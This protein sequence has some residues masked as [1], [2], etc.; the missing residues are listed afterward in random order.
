MLLDVLRGAAVMGILFMNINA[1]ALPA[2]AYDNP[3]AY[4]GDTA[5]N[6]AAWAAA[7][8]LID[9][10]MRALFSMLFGASLLLVAER[11]EARGQSALRVHGARMGVLL[12]VGLA[13][14]WLLWWG[15]ILHH[16]A[17]V[18]MVAFGLRHLP[19]RQL[20][21]TAACALLLQIAVV[22]TVPVAIGAAERAIAA[23]PA[24]PPAEA[25]ATLDEYRPSFGAPT[26]AELA[27][28]LRIHRGG[29]ANLL[30]DRWAQTSDLPLALVSAIGLET[31]GYM[32]I[33]MAAL[34]S[35]LFTGGW[36]PRRYAL[37]AAACFALT[38][39][40]Y[41]AL[42]WAEWAGG[43]DMA[44]I[45][46]AV[47]S[48]GAVLRPVMALGWV[49]LI[50]LAARR[51]GWITARVAAAGR[52]A[53]SNY[54]ASSLICS[55]IFYGYGFGLYGTV[56]RAMLVPV[57][58]AICAIMLLWSAPW[59]RRHRYGPMEWLWRSAARA[60]WQSWRGQN[61]RGQNWQGQNWRW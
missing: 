22:T 27:R 5:L 60:R 8:I 11:A 38:L 4:G 43:F 58:G 18:G 40:G 14:L 59:L 35:G 48:A 52:M 42:A 9:G 1:F 53:F 36:R 24:H 50:A 47:L 56:P 2:A 23:S 10:K 46:L 21:G 26:P 30:A 55:T 39:P 44:T 3:R 33:G 25:L 19:A 20:L 7:F 49:C 31:L 57:V 29:Y 54:L 12:L 51:G 15:D 37:M 16:Y 34:R 45:A 41:A 61:W 32:L 28:D 17:L 13:H 6:L